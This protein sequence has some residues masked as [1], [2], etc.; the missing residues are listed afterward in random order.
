[1]EGL[2]KPILQKSPLR[3]TAKEGI[4]VLGAREHNLKNINVFIPRNKITLIT[5]LSGSGK[6]TLAFDT[7]YAE[8][9]RRYLESLSVYVRY[10]IDQMK[11]PQVDFIYGLSPS[12]AID[13]KTI[14]FNPRSTVGTLTEIYDFV[15]L[16]YARAGESF[17]PLHKKLL[18]SQT[19]EEITAEIAKSPKT[20]PLYILSPIARGKKGEFSKEI[21]QCLSMGWDRAR[22]DGQWRDLGQVHK[23]EKRKDHY[24]EVLVDIVTWDRG[25]LEKITSAV[26][27]ALNLSHSFVQAESPKGQ[28]KLYSLH[29]SCPQCDFSFPDME[30]KLFSFNSPKGACASC[31]GTGRSID[32]EDIYYRHKEKVGE[33]CPQCQGGRLNELALQVKIQDLN[34][35]QL[36]AMNIVQLEKFIKALKFSG[37]RKQIVEK[38]KKPILER[39]SFLHELSLDYLSL[40]RSLSTLSGGEAQR[41]RLASQMASPVVGALYVLDEPSI[42]LHA[43]D[44]H[45]LLKAVQKIRDR[46]NTVIIVEHDEESICQ[47]DKVID[48]GPGAG[49][50]GGFLLAEGTVSEIKKNKKSLTGAYLSKKKSIPI[51]QSRF[52]RKAS[53]IRLQGLK[54]NNLK[55]INVNIPLSCLVAVSGVSGSG[56]SS[57]VTGSIEPLLLSSINKSSY[58]KGL[59]RKAYGLDLVE[60]VICIDQKP[61]GR[62]P[63]S[64][65]ATYVGLFQQIR[66]FFAFLPTARM[67]GQAPGHFSFNIPGGR[68]ENCKGAGA[69]KLEMRFLPDVFSQCEVCNGKRYTPEILNV[70]YKGKNIF[71]VLNMSVDSALKFFKNHPGINYQLKFLQ[72]VGLGYIRLGQ[73]SLSLSGGEAQR[74]K[75]SR[76]LAKKT[77]SHSFYILDEPTTGLHF[78]D[79]ERL[80]QILHRLVDQGHT[81]M[82]IEHHL[83]ILKS[84]DYLIDLG[85]GAGPAGGQLLAQAPPEDVAKNKKSLTGQ[86]LK[87]YF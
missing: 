29:L 14:S 84:C 8:G 76:E 42:G 54:T 72:D 16:L 68:C 77:R 12:I 62:S 4:Q 63:R 11:R 78:Q 43:K 31:N 64:N 18:K 21:E 35:N 81:V 5:G 86:Y 53:T 34:I 57:L 22:I 48:L 10:F 50:N 13:Q 19:A 55:N 71:D 23:L 38:I 58:P 60:R 24:I 56:K 70:F 27:G 1:M 87:T 6:S 79:V 85:P 82:V 65:P 49:E 37:T 44:H 36:S 67:R 32:R 61:I 30:P 7:L 40:N 3:K 46:G 47:A 9:Q 52:N 80:I 15:R 73:S 45:R 69:V 20:E 2:K 75:L 26:E 59:V 25:Y 33:L 74:I 66:N 17:C 51:Y 39:L 28:K 41:V 83:D